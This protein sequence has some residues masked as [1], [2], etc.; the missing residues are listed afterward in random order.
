MSSRLQDARKTD[1]ASVTVARLSLGTAD[2][3]P[4]VTLKNSQG[5]IVRFIGRGGIILSML[6][7]DR[8]GTLADVVLGFDDTARHVDDRFYIGALIGRN[9]NRI[10]NATFSLDGRR[11]E[12]SRNDGPNHLHGGAHGFNAHEWAVHPFERA[13][14]VGAQLEFESPAG[15]QGYPGTLRA[16]VVYTLTNANEFRVEYG[17]TVDAATP[18]NMAQHTYFNLNPCCARNILDHELTVFASQI[19]PVNSGLIPTGKLQPVVGTPFDFRSGRRIGAHIYDDDDQLRIGRG[20]D[21]NFVLDA[22]ANNSGQSP[23]LAA[24]LYDPASG[25]ILEVR[26]TKPGI[27]IYTGNELDQIAGGKGGAYALHAGVALETQHFPD[28]P[29]QPTFPTTIVRPG[30]A[31]FSETM[32]RFL[33]DGDTHSRGVTG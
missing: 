24:R 8:E 19:T 29:N 32:Y 5:M 26:T 18:V 3:T 23:V 27:Q 21:H 9:A 15:D 31:Y 30:E 20:Y 13:D 4:V 17:A 12:L 25:R 22:G 11:Y 33:A 7:P 1:A 2:D 6:V 10:A 28:S 14:E 16:S